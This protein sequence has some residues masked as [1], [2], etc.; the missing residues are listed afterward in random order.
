MIDAAGPT[1]RLKDAQGKYSDQV[2]I[3]TNLHIALAL[4]V[5]HQ[6]DVVVDI[7]F[8][9]WR[10]TDNPDVIGQTASGDIYMGARHVFLGEKKGDFRL[11]ISAGV[12]LPSGKTYAFSGTGK[13][14]FTALL[15]IEKSIGNWSLYANAG[16]HYLPTAV[17]DGINVGQR[18]P[19]HATVEYWII[20]DSF[21]IAVEAGGELALDLATANSPA[22]G[23]LEFKKK[24]GPVWL[25]AGG[26]TRFVND[27]A[28]AAAWR[29]F[30]GVEYT[31]KDTGDAFKP[32]SG[33]IQQQGGEWDIP[34][35]PAQFGEQTKGAGSK[36]AV[37]DKCKDKPDEGWRDG[38][39]IDLGRK[40]LVFTGVA[41]EQGRPGLLIDSAKLLDAIAEALQNSPKVR[42]RV[43][44]HSDGQAD[45]GSNLM[46]SQQRALTVMNYLISRGVDPARLSYMGMGDTQPSAAG[47]P[48]VKAGNRLELRVM[49]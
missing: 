7:P 33:P 24:A 48:A 34:T 18:I 11:G 28:G 2:G 27:A 41:F 5:G 44:V 26:G 20:P 31:W 40:L 1:V 22:E 8:T 45:S 21:S 17:Y 42:A 30:L 9:P 4:G 29:T 12:L 19:M 15:G 39:Q 47:S 46:L 13:V 35:P 3:S 14:S 10:Q 38:C 23:Y 36:T 37:P 49:E 6:T 43:E 32:A 25:I 16:Y